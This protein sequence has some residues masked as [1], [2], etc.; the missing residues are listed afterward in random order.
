M[1]I[2]T[3]KLLLAVSAIVL[4]SQLS[5]CFPV[6]AGGAVA[7]GAMAADRRT[8]G[9]YIEDQN[10]EIKAA[11]N[12][13]DQLGDKIHVNVTS[14]NRN[15]LLTGEATD[16]ASKAKAEAIAKE[17]ANVKSVV[18]ELAVAGISSISA[19]SSDTYITSK[20]KTN[21]ITENRFPPNYVKVITENSVVY[22]MGLV[23]HQEAD[24][25]VEVARSTG[26]VAKVVKVFEYID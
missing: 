19:R 4:A 23:K 18:N 8:S 9:I 15:V 17:V 24:A 14:Y 13:N 3:S 20:V 22:L 11:K 16:D 10:I 26:G 6:V 12:I 2:Q 25:A 5:G 7:G 21:M 1:R